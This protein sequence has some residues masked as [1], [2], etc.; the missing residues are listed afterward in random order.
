M[1]RYDE[2]AQANLDSI[3]VNE[4][5]TAEE[6]VEGRIGWMKMR[7]QKA[8][9]TFIDEN[10]KFYE[11]FGTAY[12]PEVD[13]E[14]VCYKEKY[15]K[16]MLMLMNINEFFN[17]KEENNKN[18]FK[19]TEDVQIAFTDDQLEKF[20]ELKTKLVNTDKML[21]AKNALGEIG[22]IVG[23]PTLDLPFGCN[24]F[25][26]LAIGGGLPEQNSNLSSLIPANEFFTDN[27]E[28]LEK[29]VP[30]EQFIQA[31]QLYQQKLSSRGW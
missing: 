27:W 24:K 8:P 6:I 22:Q 28:V 4:E 16:S 15:K 1:D 2:I 21:F 29:E 3:V 23:C 13:K 25:I 7:M 20:E 26:A 10:G 18:D 11:A 31:S 9:V 14:Y 30:Y 17:L 12:D 5:E 19:F